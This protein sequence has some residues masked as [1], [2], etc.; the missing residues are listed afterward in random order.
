MRCTSAEPMN[1]RFANRGL[2]DLGLYWLEG[3]GGEILCILQAQQNLTSFLL[4]G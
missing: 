3:Q 4:A 2:A 1:R